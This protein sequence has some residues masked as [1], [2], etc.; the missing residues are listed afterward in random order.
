MLRICLSKDFRRLLHAKRRRFRQRSTLEKALFIE[1][2]V[3][4]GVARLAIRFLP[5]CRIAPFLGRAMLETPNKSSPIVAPGLQVSWAVRTAGRYTPWESKC[6][7]QAV[8]A[9]MMLKRRRLPSTLYLGLSKDGE[10]G[11]RAHAWLRCGDRILTGGPIHRHFTQIAAFG[12][13]PGCP[14]GGSGSG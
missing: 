10:K 1:A 14:G 2:V 3:C 6:L 9:K 5:F 11:L 4:L 8:A 13:T 7:A 12:D